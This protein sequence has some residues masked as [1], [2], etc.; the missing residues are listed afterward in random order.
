M[1]LTM[2]RPDTWCGFVG[3]LRTGSFGIGHLRTPRSSV[4][5]FTQAQLLRRSKA[6]GGLRTAGKTE[7]SAR[8]V[9]QHYLL[10]GRIRCAN[11]QAEDGGQSA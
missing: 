9:K 10:R 4:E 6:A 2:W 1:T 5:D 3:L 11:L 8:P 7:R